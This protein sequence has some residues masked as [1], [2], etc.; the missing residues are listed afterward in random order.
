M[1][2]RTMSNAFA[3]AYFK[4]ISKAFENWREW[5][6]ADKHKEAIIRRT[7]DHWMKKAGKSLLAIMM[8]WKD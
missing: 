1:G 6:R 5:T 3:R 8:T 2:E 4:R 7:L